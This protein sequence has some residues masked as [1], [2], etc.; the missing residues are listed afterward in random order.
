MTPYAN[1]RGLRAPESGPQNSLVC[2]VP[3]RA[4][5]CLLVLY[6]TGGVQHDRSLLRCSRAHA[7]STE[8]TSPGTDLA[9]FAKANRPAPTPTAPFAVA[10]TALS[11]ANATS[12][13]LDG[14]CCSAA[15][16]RD[17]EMRAGKRETKGGRGGGRGRGRKKS[18][19]T[20]Q[21]SEKRNKSTA[22]NG[23]CDRHSGWGLYLLNEIR[24][25]WRV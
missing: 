15:G 18:E 22:T 8:L 3:P 1:L 16:E 13:A 6:P 20:Q 12:L 11:V 10:P 25:P 14:H 19:G 21:Q 9:S 5:A 2:C 17:R 23:C 24:I 7:K 4:A